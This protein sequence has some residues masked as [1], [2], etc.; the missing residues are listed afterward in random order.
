MTYEEALIY[1][2]NA[3]KLGSIPGLDSI[4]NLLNRLDNPQD[5]LKIVHVAG[6]N[7]KGSTISFISGI[8]AAAGYRV[9]IY[10]SPVV[11]SYREKLQ[12]ITAD[13]Y[14]DDISNDNIT[15]HE[16]EGCN[17]GLH[18]E[19][20]SEDDVCQCLDIIKF[21]CDDMV[22]KGHAH[23]TAFEIETAMAFLYMEKEQVDFLILET[24]MGGRLD[25]TNVIK[26]PICSV[27]VSVSLD[28]MQYLGNTLKEI[29]KEKAGIMKPDS[30][31]V[32][33]NQEQEVLCVFRHKADELDIPLIIADS[34][35][36]SNIEYRD[37]YTGFEYPAG[38]KNRLYRIR[39]FGKHQVQNAVLAIEVARRIRT[40][41]YKV[42]EDAICKGLWLA[43]WHGRFDRIAK[44]PDIYIDGAHNED[45]ALRIRESIEIYFTNRRLIFIIGVL[46]D[47]DYKSMLS[48]LAPLADTIITLTPQNS[49][50]LPS[51]KLANEASIYCRRVFDEKDIE[52]AIDRAYMEAGKNDVIFALGSLSFLGGLVSSIKARK[53]E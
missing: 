4:R 10:I 42:T 38:G 28:H 16:D 7:G 52:H 30:C 2:N 33:C 43:K 27:I 6:T 8:L 34:S 29:A 46:A 51:D 21:A 50:A 15:D 14:E 35:N 48:I 22:S 19:Y 11:F 45:A 40:L 36:A 12:I 17:Q 23:P 32:T 39:M 25:A 9:G 41:G 53:D 24:G 26:S 18:R 37:Y 49:R 47:K 31:A 1:I 3:E 13:K 5:R 44:A 20:I